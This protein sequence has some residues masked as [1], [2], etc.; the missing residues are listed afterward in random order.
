VRADGLASELEVE[1]LGILAKV[2]HLSDQFISLTS[3]FV[4]SFKRELLK[5][6]DIGILDAGRI[7]Y[8]NETFGINFKSNSE[9]A[10]S[11]LKDL[12]FFIVKVLSSR[13]QLS[14]NNENVKVGVNYFLRPGSVL[15]SEGAGQQLHF[16]SLWSSLH[17]AA[18][19]NQNF[20]NC[21]HIEYKH[22]NGKIGLHEFN[23]IAHS[24]DL[25][26]I[27]GPSGSGNQHS[28]I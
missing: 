21:S 3:K 9:I 2:F 19:A 8:H 18:E 27:M 13:D 23:F 1:F 5:T 14:L 26:A 22:P 11:F 4:F 24:G 17:N 6:E 28:L 12:G 7:S 20:L 15:I 25:I 10:F 16:S